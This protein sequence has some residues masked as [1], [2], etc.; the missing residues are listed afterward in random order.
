[1][2]P[3]NYEMLIKILLNTLFISIFICIFF[4]TYAA[5]I[6]EKILNYQMKFLA[7]NIKNNVSSLGNQATNIFKSQINNYDPG[8]L[9]QQDILVKKNNRKV[10]YEA[11]KSNCLYLLFVIFIIGIIHYKINKNI[12]IKNIIIYNI[13]ILCFVAVTEFSFLRYFGSQFISI[14]PNQIKL[15]IIKNIYKLTSDTTN[16]NNLDKIVKYQNN[17]NQLPNNDN[18]LNKILKYLNNNQENNQE[19]NQSNNDNHLPINDNTHSNQPNNQT[20]DNIHSNQ[21]NNQTN[22]NHKTNKNHHRNYINPKFIN[23]LHNQ[24][25]NINQQYINEINNLQKLEKNYISKQL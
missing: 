17:D 10:L 13:I 7:N 14:D 24:Q 5:H 3:I 21:P 20:N 2:Y 23:Q 6:E 25:Q 19:N 18:N 4:F 16:N 1:M 15:S 8:D 9:S 12:N 11:F 22:K